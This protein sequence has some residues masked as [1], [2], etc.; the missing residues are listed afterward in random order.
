MIRQEF[1]KLFIKNKMLFVFFGAIIIQC[2]LWSRSVYVPHYQNYTNQMIYE[3]YASQF[4]YKLTSADK[5]KIREDYYDI[6]FAEDD[7]E[8]LLNQYSAGLIEKDEY[9]NQMV[10]IQNRISK[11]TVLND[12]YNR[13][14]KGNEDYLVIENGW[15]MF[16]SSIDIEIC[17]FAAIAL[18]AI[19]AIRCEKENSML[20]YNLTTKNGRSKLAFVKISTVIIYSATISFVMYFLKLFIYLMKFGSGG[21][22]LPLIAVNGFLNSSTDLTTFQGVLVL[23]LI[24]A[25]GCIYFALIILAIAI[26]S[27][28]TAFTAT[29]AICILFIPSYIASKTEG[30]E[31]IYK[32]PLPNGLF[33][34]RGFLMGD[35]ESNLELLQINFTSL[36]SKQL[37]TVIC[38]DIIIFLI[39]TITIFAKLSGFRLRLIKKAVALTSVSI[40]LLLSGCAQS[41][42]IVFKKDYSG[43]YIYVLDYVYDKE[44]NEIVSITKDPF[45]SSFYMGIFENTLIVSRV[46]S[47]F[48]R[49]DNP[50]YYAVDLATREE[51]LIFSR[52]KIY[53]YSG[54]MDIDEIYPNV[55][56]LFTKIDY[57]TSEA[58]Y[59][60]DEKLCAVY[61]NRI[62]IV[63]LNTKK[64]KT[65]MENYQGTNVIYFEGKIY[66]RD[67][68]YYIHC[69]DPKNGDD[70]IIFDSLC[71]QFHI[72]SF[73]II[74]REYSSDNGYLYKFNGE[75]IS[76]PVSFP[77]LLCETSDGFVMMFGPMAS[78]YNSTDGTFTQIETTCP[79]FSADDDGIYGIDFSD[80]GQFIVKLDYNGKEIERCKVS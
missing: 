69:F 31:F 52:E 77:D 64:S 2:L 33:K 11:K 15:T 43:R 12:L 10:S 22:G 23:S 26:F 48:D 9:D 16:I 46:N 25:A 42:E 79:V 34:A 13:F 18:M 29:S 51:K 38:L 44:E 59:F 40:T 7:Y 73:G 4:D 67:N 60:E 39:I 53:D 27:K 68:S 74:Y 72:T 32:L 30:D 55:L 17:T 76:L 14:Y 36:T 50:G 80:D 78:I 45:E 21:G 75:I 71:G 58:I 66:Y 8:K 61:S 1:F 63:D 24:K 6:I 70:S 28:S 3:E 65:V 20:S 54:L 41:E 19:I 5:E 49:T 62:E 57:G 35:Y 56:S 37:A 47:N